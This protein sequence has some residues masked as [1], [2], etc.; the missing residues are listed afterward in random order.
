MKKSILI[1][2]LLVI[3]LFPWFFSA[4]TPVA[5]SAQG[6]AISG[7]RLISV[8]GAELTFE[9]DYSVEP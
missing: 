9:V 4:L 2:A 8:K 5:E 6:D 7:T 3:V 1:F